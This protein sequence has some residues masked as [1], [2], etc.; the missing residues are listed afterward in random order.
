MAA[1][2]RVLSG[3]T[4]PEYE[5]R[6]LEVDLDASSED[7]YDSEVTPR[8]G[9]TLEVKRYSDDGVHYFSTAAQLKAWRRKVGV[10]GGRVA[11]SCQV[12]HN[13]THTSTCVCLTLTPCCLH[14][15]TDDGEGGEGAAV[16]AAAGPCRDPGHTWH[17]V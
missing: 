7:S 9:V 11:L 15:A 1:L 4:T 12:K 16:Q 3:T 14:N 10:E 17:S 13:H 6:F 8:A 5:D 2:A